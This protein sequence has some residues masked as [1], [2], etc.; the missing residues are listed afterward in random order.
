MHFKHFIKSIPILYI[1]F[2][3]NLF[4]QNFINLSNEGPCNVSTKYLILWKLNWSITF[5]NISY[6]SSD[7][8]TFIS[9]SMLSWHSELLGL[10]IATGVELFE[11][12]QNQTVPY[13]P[14][15]KT[16]FLKKK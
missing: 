3:V 7:F 2:M 15:P 14:F 13:F 5:E 8:I 11:L 12:I 16:R 1:V 4:E 10:L 6:F 9:V